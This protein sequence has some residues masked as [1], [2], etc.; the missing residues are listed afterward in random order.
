MEMGQHQRIPSMED[1]RV[2]FE[3][4]YRA[5]LTFINEAPMVE[6]KLK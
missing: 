2:E 4:T 6:L 5:V 1:T 3:M